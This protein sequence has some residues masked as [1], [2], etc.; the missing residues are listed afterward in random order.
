MEWSG[1]EWSGLFRAE[2]EQGLSLLTVT[3]FKVLLPEFRFSVCMNNLL[4]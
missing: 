2:N 4:K 1:V 3:N